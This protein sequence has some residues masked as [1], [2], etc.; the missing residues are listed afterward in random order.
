VNEPNQRGPRRR[1][2]YSNV[3]STLALF[4]VIAGGTAL[5]AALPKNSV[6]SKTVKDES[7]K[8]RDLQSDSVDGS[9]IV[10]GAVDT[11][12][13]EDNGL[14][15]ADITDKTLTGNDVDESS[16]GRVPS[17]LL[18]GLGRHATRNPA[19]DPE[20]LTFVTCVSVSFFVP[21]QA[22]VLLIGS[23]KADTETDSDTGIGNCRLFTDQT[24]TFSASE[25]FVNVGDVPDEEQVPLT[26]VT[27][28]IGPGT[29]EFSIFCN[30]G[31]IGAIRYFDGQISAVALSPG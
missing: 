18:G 2:N 12:E 20:S 14:I 29:V 15:G 24:G 28:P 1:L 11:A 30:Q 9:E 6:T 22:R 16:L 4:L 31:I 8:A 19:C 3:V 27:P 7:L 26:F 5:A 23:V 13:V 17:A 21:A 25:V 10:E